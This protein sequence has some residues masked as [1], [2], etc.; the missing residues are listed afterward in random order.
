MQL[1]SWLPPLLTG[2][3]ILNRQP[4]SEQ[5]VRI[6]ETALTWGVLA[7]GIYGVIQYF[8][9]PGWDAFWM[10]NARMSSIGKAQPE[11]VRIFSTLDSPGPFA[12]SMGASLIVLFAR[13]GLI[14]IVAA[15]P[16]YVSF[17]L[18]S[19]RG[20][21]I[22]WAIALGSIITVTKGRLRMR[23]VGMALV[24]GLVAVPAIMT[25]S[26]GDRVSSRMETFENL[27]KDG[28]VQARLQT[29]RT[30]SVRI[31]ENPIGWGLG[32]QTYDSGVLTLFWQLG[33]P[34]G[35]LYL[36][37]LSLLFRNLL[38]GSSLFD[39]VVLG[40]AVSYGVQFFAGG[41]LLGEVT[42]VLFW[43]LTSLSI[44]QSAQHNRESSL[45]PA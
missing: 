8:V 23:L 33:W 42:G 16:G 25:G 43:S 32:S 39:K 18:A 38:H 1:V 3:Y 17:M 4:L 7:M 14:P 24:V 2:F 35:L 34:G 15:V 19:V 45:E 31:L 20:A 37:G 44:A 36:F 12:V 22:G 27:E 30:V 21:W 13:R 6:V 10:Q 28:S 5:H 11:Q 9:L 26:I 29:Y 41:Q 40:I